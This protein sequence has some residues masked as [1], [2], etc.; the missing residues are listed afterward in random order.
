MAALA[1]ANVS[2]GIPSQP[3][4]TPVVRDIQRIQRNVSDV[5]VPQPQTI[6]MGSGPGQVPFVPV[7][8]MEQIQPYLAS[9]AQLGQASIA[10][11]DALNG[12]ATPPAAASAGTGAG[13]GAGAGTGTGA[14]AGAAGP[15]P[16][17]TPEQIARRQAARGTPLDVAPGPPVGT[18]PIAQPGSDS[19]SGG[20]LAGVWHFIVGG[21]HISIPNPLHALGTINRAIAAGLAGGTGGGDTV[22]VETSG[23]ATE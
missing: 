1:Q 6:T 9:L 3:D 22:P 5:V 8:G 16:M 7:P 18:A 4:F 12:A 15:G 11:L 21:R 20:G 13:A 19:G 17:G 10:G 2:P 14:G 23:A